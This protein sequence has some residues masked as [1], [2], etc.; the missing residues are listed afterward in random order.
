VPG[1]HPGRPRHRVVGAGL[2]L[3]LLLGL[4]SSV[5]PSSA[6]PATAATARTSS[7]WLPYWSISASTTSVVA[8]RHLFHTA[9]PFWYQASCSS[10][11]GYQGAGDSGIVKRLRG[12]GLRVV[13]TVTSTMTPAQAIS[14]LSSTT[15]RRAHVDRL[16]GT[17]RRG[18]FDGLDLN[19]EHLAL[20]KDPA[21]ARRVRAAFSALVTDTC[22]ALH[23]AAKTCVVTVMPRTDDTSSLWRGKLIPAVYDYAAIGA[24]AD[25]VRVMAYDQHAPGTTAGP[26]GGFAWTQRI[27][28]YTASKVPPRKVEIGAPMYGRDW[29]G[30]SATTLTGRAARDLAARH[31]ARI[32]YHPQHRAPTFSYRSGGRTH[33]VWFSDGRSLAERHTLARSHGFAGSAF[34]AVGQEDPAVWATVGTAVRAAA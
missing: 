22:A 27:A 18:G 32:T 19:Y 25:R 3:A 14:C 5:S 24:K 23:K 7:A 34:W 13:P 6:P 29:V 12:A 16:V 26:V 8:N 11:S 20:T 9:S 4:L 30:T 31:G 28:R 33:V 15:S 17:A 2:V 10:V 21:T 1:R